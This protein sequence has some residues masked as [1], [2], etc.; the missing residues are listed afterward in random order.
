VLTTGDAAWLVAGN[1][2]GAGIFFTPGD[3]ARQL[4]GTLGPL[5]AWILGGALALAGAAI[6]GELGARLPHAGG[7]YQ[8]L[9]RAF[10]PL[11]GFLMGW[12]AFVLS[13]SAAAAAMSRVAVGYLVVLV[14]GAEQHTLLLERTVGPALLIGLTL[15]NV[16]GAKVGG[17]TTTIL[18]SIPLL[19]LAGIAAYGLLLGEARFDWPSRV[20]APP[21]GSWPL[22]LGA[23]MVPVF[24]TYSGWNGAAYLAGELERPERTLPR[25]LLLG[26]AGVTALYLGVNVLLLGLLGDGLAASTT[27]GADAVRRLLPGRG[28]GV[29]PLIVAVAIAS[30][31]NVTL[32]A[33]ARIYYAM[34]GERLAPRALARVNRRGVPA[35]ALWG[36]GIWSAALAALAPAGTLI[37]WATLAILL[38]SSLTVAALFVLRRRD[39]TFRSFRCPGYPVTPAVYLVASLGVAVSSAL[40][41]PW[42]ALWGLLLVGAGFPVYALWRA[43]E[44]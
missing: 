27:P 28:E 44:R 24:F 30:S 31:A 33:G 39:P 18:T 35:T 22:A 43:T 32:M 14:S 37:R 20:L 36:A 26:T 42:G 8:Y 1:M 10:G 19:A 41:D 40:Y 5:A 11:W 23:A 17:R 7:D 4:P 21:S 29:L 15:L 13:F 16:A 12:A 25:A 2:I 38:L 3:V 9:T 34:A 6:Y